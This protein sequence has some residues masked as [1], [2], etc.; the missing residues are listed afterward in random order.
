MCIS[1]AQACIK[2]AAKFCLC[3]R[4]CFTSAPCSFFAFLSY[5]QFVW[6]AWHSR[7]IFKYH[8]LFGMTGA[9]S[10]RC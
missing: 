2:C 1:T 3:R 10:A 9:V 8:T 5:V 6:Q 7:D 4:C